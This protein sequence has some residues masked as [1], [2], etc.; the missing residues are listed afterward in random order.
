MDALEPRDA[1]PR[2][3]PPSTRLPAN[4]WDLRLSAGKRVALSVPNGHTLAVV[5]LRGTVQLNDQEILRSAQLAVFDHDGEV[6]SIEAN[7]DATALVL[8]GEPLREPIVGYGPFV[9]NTKDEIE[10]AIRDFNS[11][12]F[13]HVNRNAP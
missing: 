7:N 9:M 12:R 5:V 3:L 8:S 1:G 10:Q 11:G 6:F 2:R 4:V 13:G